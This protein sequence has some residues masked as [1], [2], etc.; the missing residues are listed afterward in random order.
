VAEPCR[1]LVL[2][3]PEGSTEL[4]LDRPLNA[5][6]IVRS[7]DLAD[8]IH[9]LREQHFDG[10]LGDPSCGDSL[11]GLVELLQAS[12]IFQALPDGVAILDRNMRVLW[13]NPMF[14]SWCGGPAT[15]KS[16][17]ELL[18]SPQTQPP[19]PFPFTTTPSKI[20]TFRLA[21]DH[22]YLELRI[23]P[24]AP[25]SDCQLLCLGRDITAETQRQQKL[26]A[27]HKAGLELAGLSTEH[28]ADM[29]VEE[30]IELLKSNIRRF[31]RD[32]LQYEVVEIR[33]LDPETGR[34]EPLL[35][36]G[37]TPEAA[38][39]VLFARPAG[40]GVTGYVAAMGV[41]VLCPD[42]A[43][44]PRYLQGAAGAHS[45]LTVPLIYQQKVVGTFNVES[46]KLNTFT[47]EDLQFAEIF[48][49]EIAFA[50]HNLELL[51]AEMRNAA[52]RSCEA[53][54]REVAMPADDILAASTSLIE[55]YIGHDQELSEKLKKIISGV[56]TIKLVIQKVGEEMT[57]RRCM[58][59]EPEPERPRL[60]G[61]RVLVADD[62]ERVRRSANGLLGRFGCIVDTARDGHEALAMSKLSTYDAIIADIR[63][64]DMTGYDFFRKLHEAQP[65]AQVI[66]MT[67]YGYDPS[68][69]IVKARQEGMKHVLY[70][71]FRIDQLLDALN[72]A[73]AASATLPRPA[74]VSKN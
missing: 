65:Q 10:I 17:P 41:G 59:G 74:A 8:A 40:N 28:I 30:R 61:L 11:A 49:R 52:T 3:G 25:D 24:L 44:D 70:K 71:P 15:G 55:R 20:T 51:N 1:I 34:L 13:A 46:P 32:L 43:C 48:C 19:S 29:S 5:C 64:P 2:Q 72:H 69:S 66:L 63:L 27:L 7:R 18:W 38:Q 42:T 6:E 68:H 60:K 21:C 35:E 56:R 58:P 23:G 16:L 9:K 33:L 4:T 12:R 36:E 73:N 37:M 53:V 50:L 57:P 62:D 67:A 14:E 47:E 45:S 39:R 31:T 22:R 54:S 26:D